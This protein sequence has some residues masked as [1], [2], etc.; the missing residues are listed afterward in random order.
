MSCSS[1]NRLQGKSLFLGGLVLMSGA[2]HVWFKSVYTPSVANEPSSKGG[3]M[4]VG[5]AN[6][7]FVRPHTLVG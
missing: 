1:P 4:A 5:T 6:Y 3:I 2:G 7:L